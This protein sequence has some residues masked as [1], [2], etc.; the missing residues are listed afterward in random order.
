MAP[1]EESALQDL[2]RVLRLD[3][4]RV[5][6]SARLNNGPEWQ[7]LELASADEVLAVDASLVQWPA[8]V[9]V[10]LLGAHPE[11]A[12]CQFEVRNISPSSGMIEDPITGSLN[13]AIA[14]WMAADGRLTSQLTTSQG[15]KLGREG[16][17][18]IRPTP[19]KPDRVTIGGHVQVVVEG[20]VRL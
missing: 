5:I 17:V 11:G 16:R 19:G 1:L 12:E 8:Y 14:K 2:C 3:R 13:S 7:L 20:T 6:R 18:F 9:G 4:A 15:T 10:S